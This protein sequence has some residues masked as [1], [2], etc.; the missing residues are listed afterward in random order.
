M[1]LADIARNRS[2][3]V[4]KAKSCKLKP[5]QY[6]GGTFTI[7]NLAAYEADDFVALVNPPEA[8]ILAVG[9]MKKTPV[10]IGDSIQIVPLIIMNGSFDHRPLDGSDGA[11][12]MQVL[13]SRLESDQWKII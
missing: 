12:F 3:L 9:K 11:V 7:S 8:G 2:E 10:V 13:V 4:A 1:S 5:E 6:C